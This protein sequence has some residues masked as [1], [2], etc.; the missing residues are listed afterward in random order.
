MFQHRLLFKIWT[1]LLQVFVACG[2]QGILF[3]ATICPQFSISV[4]HN[5]NITALPNSGLGRQ[6]RHLMQKYYNIAAS[7]VLIT[8][9]Q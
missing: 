6:K 3:N 2:M 7:T 5:T 8:K 4:T 1:A 9:A